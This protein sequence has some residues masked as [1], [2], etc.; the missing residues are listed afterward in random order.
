MD[1]NTVLLA[2]VLLIQGYL[3]LR[4]SRLEREVRRRPTGS[5]TRQPGKILPLQQRRG[6][7]R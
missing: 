1:L 5:G 4:L 6:D 2:V 3:F 7:P